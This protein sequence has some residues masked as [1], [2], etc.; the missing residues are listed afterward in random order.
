MTPELKL[1][2]ILPIT[3]DSREAATRLADRIREYSG[4]RQIAY[5]DDMHPGI[6]AICTQFQ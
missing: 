3:L 5:S 4:G 2:N 6:P 1:I